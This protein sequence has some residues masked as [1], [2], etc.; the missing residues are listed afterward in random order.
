MYI[1][2]TN[3]PQNNIGAVR[4]KCTAMKKLSLVFFGKRLNTGYSRAF[5]CN[6]IKRIVLFFFISQRT[7]HHNQPFYTTVVSK[8][9]ITRKPNSTVAGKT[10]KFVKGIELWKC[11]EF[12]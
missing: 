12:I 10:L 6:E 8:F 2:D 3:G 5:S 4:F 1:F 7:S 11:R 9:K